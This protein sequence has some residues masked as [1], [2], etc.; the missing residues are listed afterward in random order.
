M[1]WH[2]EPGAGRCEIDAIVVMGESGKD[3]I[4]I[5]SQLRALLRQAQ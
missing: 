2:R 4:A 3:N 1:Q 5:S